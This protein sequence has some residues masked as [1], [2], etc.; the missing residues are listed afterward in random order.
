MNRKSDKSH[1]IIGEKH[2][3]VKKNENKKK[4]IE[5]PLFM[6]LVGSKFF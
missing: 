3:N 4:C 5:K 6:V 1:N 2:L